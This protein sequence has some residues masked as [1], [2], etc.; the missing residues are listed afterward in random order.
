M[1]AFALITL[2]ISAMH[3]SLISAGELPVFTWIGLFEVRRV[4]FT[5][6]TIQALRKE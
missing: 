2:V 5:E 4:E 1:L 6:I 3:P